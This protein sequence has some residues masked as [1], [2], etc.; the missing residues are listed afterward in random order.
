MEYTSNSKN[1]VRVH[2]P[3]LT[4]AERQKRMKAI[5]RA[6]TKL[7]MDAEEAKRKKG[8]TA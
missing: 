4:D 7:L 1:I 5:K 3:E 6:A 8:A 2:R